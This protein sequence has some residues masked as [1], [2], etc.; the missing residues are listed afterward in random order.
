MNAVSAVQKFFSLPIE[1]PSDTTVLE[2]I[3]IVLLA[4]CP[5]LQHYQG[6]FQDAGTVVM[7]LLFIFFGIRLLLKKEWKFAAVLPLII[8][9]L[10]EIVNH[11]VGLM[12]ISREALLLAYFVAAASGAINLRYFEKTVIRIAMLASVLLIVQY[13]CYYVFGFH[14]QLVITALLNDGAKQWVLLAQTGR[15]SVTGSFTR[16]YRPSAFF[17]EPSHVTLYCF[18]ALALIVLSPNMKRSHLASAMLLSLGIVLST[19]GMGIAL[20]VGIWGLFL[21]HRLMGEGSI[22]ERMK[23]LFSPKSLIWIG[24]FLAVIVLMYVTVPTIRSSVNRIFINSSGGNNA[25]EGRM[26]S[27]IKAVKDLSGWE[28]WFGKR[29]WGK[30]HQWNMAGFFYTFY[31]QGFIGMLL[32][33]GFYFYSLFKTKNSHFWIALIV[34]GLSLITV[35]THAAFYML[36]YVL[37]LLG[38]YDLANDRIQVRNFAK[39]V[40]SAVKQKLFAQKHDHGEECTDNKG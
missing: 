6:V 24:A 12:E 18:A 8:F 21:L 30:V 29:D 31:T 27:G 16:F 40:I 10:Y 23:K 13:I 9:S 36:F 33:Y 17:L 4:L 39:P 38:G 14:L 20:V 7:L 3:C 32:S 26:S 1:E 11:G 19:S 37:V 25:I 35:H 22:R 28:F 15:I 34:I 5:L 2:K